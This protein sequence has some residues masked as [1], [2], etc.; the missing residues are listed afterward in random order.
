[1]AMKTEA[2]FETVTLDEIRHLIPKAERSDDEEAL[3]AMLCKNCGHPADDHSMD[4]NTCWHVCE[5]NG[6]ITLCK[7][8]GW[9]F[10]ENA[11]AAA[12]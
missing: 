8:P 3:S 1:M 2:T 9:Q 6:T 12:S 11:E 4:N 7:C 10:G 5:P